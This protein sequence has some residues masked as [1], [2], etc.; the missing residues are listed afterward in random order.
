M[1][2][3]RIEKYCE[4]QGKGR[5]LLNNEELLL[6]YSVTI[7]L[8]LLEFLDSVLIKREEKSIHI[9]FLSLP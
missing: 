3:S 4:W 9:F 1:W 8:L 6:G 5:Y 7:R 2:S